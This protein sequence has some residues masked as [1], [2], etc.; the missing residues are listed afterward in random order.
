MM[1]TFTLT[2]AFTMVKEKNEFDA[3]CCCFCLGKWID[4]RNRSL[5]SRC[6]RCRRCRTHT[7]AATLFR[8]KLNEK[9]FG[10]YSRAQCSK[11]V[12]T[13][14]C[15]RTVGAHI[16]PSRSTRT[17][18]SL[19]LREHWT[20]CVC[21]GMRFNKMSSTSAVVASSCSRQQSARA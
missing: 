2:V 10:S 15:I 17:H 5:F 13:H 16:H 3:C 11:R 7:W 18:T 12:S 4:R 19:V 20:S 8:Y 21:F 14:L 1:H 9:L 6:H